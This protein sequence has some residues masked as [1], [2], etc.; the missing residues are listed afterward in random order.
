MSKRENQVQLLI[1][2]PF[3]GLG[4]S[5]PSPTLQFSSSPEMQWQETV[6]AEDSTSR[7]MLLPG[8]LPV[9]PTP[10]L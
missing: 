5:P 7:Q 10:P 4:P 1:P 6:L 3:K 2:P 9:L 8:P